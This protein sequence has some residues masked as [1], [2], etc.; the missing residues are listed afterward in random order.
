MMQKVLKSDFLSLPPR[1][2]PTAT[3]SPWPREPLE[4]STP[5]TFTQWGCPW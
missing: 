3:L 1:A 5:G 2:T 4:T